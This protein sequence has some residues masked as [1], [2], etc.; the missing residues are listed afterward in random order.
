MPDFILTTGASTPVSLDSTIGKNMWQI[1][2]RL[3][4]HHQ[5][6]KILDKSSYLQCIADL[7]KNGYPRKYN[8]ISNIRELP[9]NYHV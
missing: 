2:K 6:E 8:E 9:M 5:H 3:I 7:Y 4:N 1:F